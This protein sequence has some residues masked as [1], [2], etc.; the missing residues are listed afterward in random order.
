MQRTSL[1]I[2]IWC[3]YLSLFGGNKVENRAHI[4]TV[5]ASNNFCGRFIIFPHDISDPI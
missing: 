1:A 2:K 3:K 4:S 5:H